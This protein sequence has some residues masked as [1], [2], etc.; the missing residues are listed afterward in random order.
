M[1]EFPFI[2]AC[3]LQGVAF[4]ALE[5]VTH[6]A[7]PEPLG[8]VYRDT[9]I[10][11]GMV[12]IDIIELDA[13]R[14]CIVGFDVGR[15]KFVTSWKEANNPPPG[16]GAIGPGVFELGELRVMDKVRPRSAMS[17]AEYMAKF[18][19]TSS[20]MPSTYNNN[21]ITQLLARIPLIDA[22][23]M[24]LVWPTASEDDISPSLARQS[25]SVGTDRS[26]FLLNNHSLS[27]EAL[28]AALDAQEMEN[29]TSL[30]L[31][32]D[33]IRSTP[34]QIM[35][36][37]SG[38]NT[39]RELYFLQSPTRQ[40]DALSTQFFEELAARPQILRRAKV[41]LAGAYSSA[42]RKRIWLPTTPKGLTSNTADAVQ[43]AP[44]G[45]FPVQQ[46]LVRHQI[47]LH[48]N[49][50]FG[51]NYIHLGDALLKPERFAT[52]FL[53]Y[54]HSLIQSVGAISNKKAY[55]FS[56]SSA[57]ASLTADPLTAAEVSPILA[58]NFAIAA[59]FSPMVRNLVP[60]GWTVN[61]S[62]EKHWDRE[63][64]SF[65]NIHRASLVQRQDLSRFI[66]YAF[67]RACHQCIVVDLPLRT[68][69][70]PE[71][72]EVVGLKKFLAATAPEVDQAIVDQRLHNLAEEL[73][74]R[75]DQGILPPGI[76]P[77]S[78]LSQAEAANMLL[79]FLD[80]A[81]KMKKRLR[82]A[83]EENPE[84]EFPLTILSY[85]II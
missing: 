41:M 61:V 16:A 26:Q 80:D 70:G 9:S 77:L 12:V 38:A 48:G 56:F 74:G 5:G 6:A 27:V 62:L 14:Y 63:A 67:V 43:V 2:A 23:A 44:L 83:M 68:T 18:D 20:V 32:I 28:S 25:L 29:V 19:R 75:S 65:D 73:A 4:D 11:W 8:T 45:V 60:G 15:M 22:A 78:V 37:L 71:E 35:D 76:E 55:L 82:V 54:L 52:G 72:L 40:S 79:D 59:E 53:L 36:V 50:K 85:N 33:S 3:L 66:R 34:G 21:V 64:A 84:G 13:V 39:L 81:K 10:E 42:L 58:E 46:M 49:I 51:Y 30:S 24:G 31:C 47:D 57:P 1:R 17:A 69:P 7:R